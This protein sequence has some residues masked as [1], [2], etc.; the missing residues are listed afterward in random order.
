MR[1]DQLIR[2]WKILRLL[3]S[4]RRGLTALEIGSHV[5]I[6]PRTVYRDLQAIEE[7][8]FPIYNDRSAGCSRWKL[9][10]GSRTG[11]SLPFTLTELLSLHMG[12]GLLNVFEGTIFQDGIESLLEKVAASL[13][14]ETFRFLENISGQ[15]K[16]G[17][18]PPKKYELSRQ[19]MAELSK[20][21]AKGVQVEIGYK[22]A[23]TEQETL[24]I[25]DP[26]LIW[27]MSGAFYLIGRCHLRGA[28]RTFAMDRITSFRALKESFRYP[29][30]F[31]LADFL[32]TAFR[33]MTGDPQTIKV[34]FFPGAARVV[35]ERI[36]HPTQELREQEDGSLIITLEVPINYE[37]IS[38]ILGF[39]SAAEVLQPASLRSRLLK[40]LEASAEQ[41]RSHSRARTKIIADKKISSNLS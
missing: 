37:V 7:A 39:G 6:L 14:P 25:V 20:A 11:L 1:G 4:R 16:V 13:P 22:A 3:E 21:V 26:Y 35:R 41:Y 9:T 34:R 15:V 5:D 27:A 10:D 31:R 18:G 28:V 40:E 23:S 2:Q 36:W 19:V 24:R 17:F 32:Q 33:V 8:G 29:K 38:W 12:R 30:N